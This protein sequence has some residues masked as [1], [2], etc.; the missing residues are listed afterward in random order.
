MVCHAFK[1]R[2]KFDLCQ[3]QICQ[4][5]CAHELSSALFSLPCSE[6]DNFSA[7]LSRT[8]FLRHKGCSTILTDLHAVEK[9]ACSPSPKALNVLG[10]PCK[11]CFQMSSS[12]SRSGRSGFSM[13]RATANLGQ[14][15]PFLSA[16]VV[17]DVSKYLHVTLIICVATVNASDC[18]AS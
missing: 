17:W 3:E 5:R 18:I 15:K 6:A 11:I 16:H 1:A 4:G 7:P 9:P 2:C 12:F 10:T 8:A 14:G 13:S